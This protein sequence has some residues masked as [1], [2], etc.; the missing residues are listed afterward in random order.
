MQLYLTLE[1]ELNHLTKEQS[2]FTSIKFLER[3]YHI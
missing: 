2:L 1:R 3:E